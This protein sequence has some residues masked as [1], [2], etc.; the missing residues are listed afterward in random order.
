MVHV[1]PGASAL[2]VSRPP[3]GVHAYSVHAREIDHQT[4]VAHR[5]PGDVM[6][7][8]S[9]RDGELLVSAEVHGGDNIGGIDAARDEPRTTIDHRVIYLAR[10]I[11]AL[12]P[13][14]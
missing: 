12:V 10:R 1:A 11:V 4:S 14:L 8:T 3:L 5:E 2:S 9:N 13:G 6:T 7:A